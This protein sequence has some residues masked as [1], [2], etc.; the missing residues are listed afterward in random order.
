MVDVYGQCAQV[1]LVPFG[2]NTEAGHVT[3]TPPTRPVAVRTAVTPDII[4]TSEGVAP[5]IEASSTGEYRR[6]FRR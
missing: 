4:P 1:D 2:D 5:V 3:T 6:N